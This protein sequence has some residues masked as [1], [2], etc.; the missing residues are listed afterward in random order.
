MKNTAFLKENTETKDESTKHLNLATRCGKSFRHP[1]L[2]SA[3]ELISIFFFSILNDNQKEI[4][5]NNFKT[6]REE[7]DFEK[8]ALEVEGYI[9]LSDSDESEDISLIKNEELKRIIDY[10]MI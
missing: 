10:S 6:N 9:E 2:A 4:L 1:V 7:I 3:Q 5:I 8:F